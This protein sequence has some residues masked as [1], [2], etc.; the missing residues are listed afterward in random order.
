[1]FIAQEH[2]DSTD[3]FTIYSPVTK[4]RWK[5]RREQESWIWWGSLQIYHWPNL[6]ECTMYERE[7]KE[8]MGLS[9][10]LKSIASRKQ[11]GVGLQRAGLVEQFTDFHRKRRHQTEGMTKGKTEGKAKGKKITCNEAKL[12]T[13]HLAPRHHQANPVSPRGGRPRPTWTPGF[14]P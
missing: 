4:G 3:F 6:R 1:M 7:A 8:W 11:F 10:H 13:N 5:K 2:Y 14:R 12:A 9:G